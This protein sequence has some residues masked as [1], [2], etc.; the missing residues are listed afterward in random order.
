VSYAD[1]LSKAIASQ[2]G[3]SGGLHTGTPVD[4][5]GNEFD[6]LVTPTNVNSPPP[7]DWPTDAIEAVPPNGSRA[8]VP[9]PPA[10]ETVPDTRG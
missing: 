3:A 9:I 10:L 5:R 4:W 2:Q 7:P 8:G 1:E 6:V